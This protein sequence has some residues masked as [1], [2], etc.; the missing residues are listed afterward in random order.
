MTIQN[1]DSDTTDGSLKQQTGEYIETTDTLM[2]NV[3]VISTSVKKTGHPPPFP[4]KLAQDHILSWS[5][6]GDTVLDPMCGSGTTCLAAKQLDRK[7]IGI[8]ISQEYCDIATKR[9]NE[10]LI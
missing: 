8:D 2:N 4:E 10:I 3:W 1:Q 5:N 6:P 9:V 7:F